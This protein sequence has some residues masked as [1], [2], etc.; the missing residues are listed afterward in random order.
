MSNL[1][2][3]PDNT[4]I[5][6]E[7]GPIIAKLNQLIKSGD[8]KRADAIGEK[9]G[10]LSR[11][12][13]QDL[14]ATAATQRTEGKVEE[15]KVSET[16]DPSSK[17][18]SPELQQTLLTTLKSRFTTNS[19]LHPNTNWADVERALLASPE[20]LWSLQKL[21]ETGGEP[22][23]FLDEEDAFVFGD[24]SSES[25]SGRRNVVFDKE[26]ED[27]ERKNN[28]QAVFNGNAA[29][30]VQEW[31]VDFM[32]ELQYRGLQKF[33]QL[34]RNTW[35]WLKTPQDIRK[36]GDALVGDR[37]NFGVNV[38]QGSALRHRGNFGFRCALRVKK[39]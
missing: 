32:D 27:L 4:G 31:N 20:T 17:E 21:E 19:K 36:A 14:A 3:A 23:V 24:T 37:G 11:Q 35:S 2:V 9:L 28:P 29:D 22:D 5:T 8:V 30:K 25:P 34:D 39:V 7:L 16:K 12:V 33:K 26:A 6:Q 38:N 15:T 10:N 1:K 13:S 18:L